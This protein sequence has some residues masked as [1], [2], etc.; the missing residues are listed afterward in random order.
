M[1]YRSS[2]W[3]RY[4]SDEFHN[5]K[6]SNTI[7]FDVMNKMKKEPNN[8]GAKGPFISMK[9]EFIQVGLAKGEHAALSPLFRSDICYRG[10]IYNSII[11][12]YYSSRCKD[13]R[14]EDVIATMTTPIKALKIGIEAAPKN[15]WEERKLPVMVSIVCNNFVANPVFRQHLINTRNT[16]IL[17]VS[18]AKDYFWGVVKG[19][20]NRYR[21]YNMLGKILMSVR[22][23][24]EYS[25]HTIINKPTTIKKKSVPS[26]K[27]F[28]LE[29]KI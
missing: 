13:E 12:A 23:S 3:P 9:K 24:S 2:L 7:F 4:L 5:I 25:P 19:A 17:Y 8:R 11:Q 18:Y 22:K 26:C 27:S 15:R 6:N 20:N 10:K 28:K 16:G 1:N 29:I 21:G 14:V